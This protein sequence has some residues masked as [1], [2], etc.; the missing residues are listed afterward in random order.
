MKTAD[1]DLQ[2]DQLQCAGDQVSQKPWLPLTST[3]VLPAL[4]HQ[5]KMKKKE[6]IL[7]FV[8]FSESG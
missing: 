5:H 7:Y 3:R 8:L 2:L 1:G 6:K 4:P